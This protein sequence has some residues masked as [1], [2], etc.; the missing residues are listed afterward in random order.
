MSDLPFDCSRWSPEFA[1]T[2]AECDRTWAGFMHSYFGHVDPADV[3]W[4]MMCCAK[5][6]ASKER[7]SKVNKS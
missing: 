6:E 4:H 2:Y 3:Q 1:A 5:A 7:L